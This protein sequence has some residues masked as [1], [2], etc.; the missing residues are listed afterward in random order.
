MEN[1]ASEVRNNFIFLLSPLA[2]APISFW[3]PALCA[4]TGM[5]GCRRH[6]M[7]TAAGQPCTPKMPLSKI[8][9]SK[10]T[11]NA[12]QWIKILPPGSSTPFMAF[13][14]AEFPSIW[15]SFLPKLRF[16][17]AR[18]NK[19]MTQIKASLE[20]NGTNESIIQTPPFCS[21]NCCT[22]ELL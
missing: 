15:G 19:G 1:E 16:L 17:C 14:S 10:S 11:W 6:C 5:R 3:T 21:R 22:P 8:P 20:R 13:P 18:R 7:G 9:P 2:V 12:Q 4:G